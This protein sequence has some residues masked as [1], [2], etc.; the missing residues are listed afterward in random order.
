MGLPNYRDLVTVGGPITFA[1]NS[2]VPR[3]LLLG[4]IYKELAFT[5]TGAPTLAGA[6]NTQAALAQGDAWSVVKRIRLVVNGS[7]VIWDGTGEQL[8]LWNMIAYGRIPDLSFGLGD[9]AT[10]NP[11]FTSVLFLPLWT[12]WL[13][14]PYDTLLNA[15]TLA[16]VTVEITWGDYTSLNASASAW[17]TPPQITVHGLGSTD[18]IDIAKFTGRRVLHQI[19]TSGVNTKFSVPLRVGPV[20]GQF[21]INTKDTAT[22][23]AGQPKDKDAT[24]ALNSIAVAA[25]GRT[26]SFS[27][28]QLVLSEYYNHRNIDPTFTNT[29]GGSYSGLFRN[30]NNNYKSWL[31]LNLIPEGALGQG[32]DT[33]NFSEL[34]LDFDVAFATTQIT[35]IPVQYMPY[36][37]G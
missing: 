17:T 28:P 10:A 8:W 20:Y 19:V 3:N 13:A 36:K 2:S 35:I 11:S 5:L 1:A 26:Y 18:Q 31:F 27:T 33:A 23:V 12:P 32:V 6:S 7:D 34:R 22:L 29:A 30:S 24:A 25:G 9:G 4:M 16:S 15:G 14:K 21:L 37:A